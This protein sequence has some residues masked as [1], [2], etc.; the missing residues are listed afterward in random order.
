MNVYQLTATILMLC[1]LGESHSQYFAFTE[2]GGLLVVE[3]ESVDEVAAGW[4]EETEFE[5][6]TDMSYFRYSANNQLNNPGNG[7]LEYPIFIQ[8][9]G[10][11]QF[12][13]RNLIAEGTSTTDANDSWLKIIGSAYYGQKNRSNGDVSIVC[14][15]GYDSATN[16]CPV[17][18][19]EDGGGVEPVGSGS[20][21]WFK[22]YRSGSGDWV[23]STRTSD[24]DAH[25]IFVRFDYPGIYM[26]QVSGRSKDHAIDRMVLYRTDYVGD[27]LD[28]KILE[29]PW[30]DVDLIFMDGFN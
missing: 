25:N 6:Y 5:D 4:S 7:L 30:L 24:S 10:L 8:N 21:G 19:D 12:Q 23:W 17:D 20:D 13:W 3:I 27:P 22:V 29:S 14:P 16:E 26:I 1:W 28:V 15:K 18:L 2:Q 9:T 11:Y